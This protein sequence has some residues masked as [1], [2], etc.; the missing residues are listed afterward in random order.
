MLE[1]AGDRDGVGQVAL[2]GRFLTEPAE[3]VEEGAARVGIV[4]PAARVVDEVSDPGSGHRLE[5]VFL[6]G[7]VAV[8]RPRA[9][10]GAGGDLVERHAVTRSGERVPC[11]LQ[12]PVPVALR[13]GAQ[14]AV[15]HRC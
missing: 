1:R 13:V 12:H 4:G 6:G 5:Q 3:E 8:D 9:D 14:Q 15:R 2:C 7:E 10:P 11:R